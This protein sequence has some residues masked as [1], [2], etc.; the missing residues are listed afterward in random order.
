[1]IMAMTAPSIKN[2][3]NERQTRINHKPPYNNIRD[4][5]FILKGGFMV[6]RFIQIFFFGQHKS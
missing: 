5:P 6:F 1:M 3:K 2:K 4:R